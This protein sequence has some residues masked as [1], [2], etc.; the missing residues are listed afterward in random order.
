[1][2]AVPVAVGKR[3]EAVRALALVDVNRGVVTAVPGSKESGYVYVAW[4]SN[5]EFVFMSGGQPGEKRTLVRY[6]LGAE[7]AVSIPVRVGDFYGMAAS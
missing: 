2:L 1:M 3:Y 6:Q 4:S 7:R 5:G